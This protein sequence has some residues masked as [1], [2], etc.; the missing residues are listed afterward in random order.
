[1]YCI[2]VLPFFLQYLMNAKNLIIGLYVMLKPTL[3]SPNNFIHIW[4]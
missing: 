3:M 2:I 4:T 1:M